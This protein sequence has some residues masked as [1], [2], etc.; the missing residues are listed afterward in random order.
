MFKR[1]SGLINISIFLLLALCVH[2]GYAV[3]VDK[4]V[5]FGDS[6][7][8]TGNI[9]S[10]SMAA[11]KTIP[12]L[13]II[14]KNPP[15]YEGRF[16]NG[17]VWIES[18]SEGMKIPYDNYAYGGAWAETTIESHVLT[19]FSLM[20]QVNYFLIHSSLDF[21]KDKHLYII[22][23]GSNDYVNGRIGPSEDVTKNTVDS[24]KNEIEWLID[25]GAKNFLIFNI[26]DLSLTPDV[27]AKGPNF[28][29]YIKKLAQLHNEKLAEMMAKLKKDHPDIL[30]VFADAAT[31]FNDIVTNPDKYLLK[32]VKE[33][34]YG[35]GFFLGTELMDMREVTAAKEANIDILNNTSLRI[36]YL[37]SRLAAKGEKPC[38]NP[39]EYLFWDQLHPTRVVH[40]IIASFSLNL[41]HENGIEGKA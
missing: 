39:D 38:D 29:Q 16:S 6:L 8:D 19:P 37:N 9:Y 21:H 2:T 5:A 22:W 13:P 28:A 1:I 10:L 24:I 33:A 32:N 4:I 30:F 12:L 40:K 11:H 31:A 34:C 14:P 7:T 36:A 25:Y 23:S 18:L 20:M 3:S 41:L 17:P 15:Y 27:T 26:V 35:G